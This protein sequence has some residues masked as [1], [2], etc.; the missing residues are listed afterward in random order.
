M[1]EELQGEDGT[2][3]AAATMHSQKTLALGLGGVWERMGLM[4]K[5]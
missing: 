3:I 2:I 1:R 5:W 4:R